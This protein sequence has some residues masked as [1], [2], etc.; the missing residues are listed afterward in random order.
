MEYNPKIFK[1][2]YYGDIK[3]DY[4]VNCEGVVMNS[5]T[6]KTL[7]WQMLQ[8]QLYYK[9]A[10][11]VKPLKGAKWIPVHRLVATAFIPNPLN[12]PC[13]NHIDGN[14][15]NNHVSNLEWVTYRENTLHALH[16]GLKPD[17]K[18][19]EDQVREI[20]RLLSTQRYTNRQIAEMIG[21][22]CTKG[23]VN[24]IR[25]RNSWTCISKD[26]DLPPIRK[27]KVKWKKRFPKI[28]ELLRAGYNNKQIIKIHPIPEV[29]KDAY[30]AIIST[31]KAFLRQLGE[32]Q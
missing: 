6:S 31:R 3:T 26:Y 2:I 23:M 11:Y 32:I 16:H 20:C 4:V 8:N 27:M 24:D 1:R 5:K 18:L 30:T 25:G 17:V 9:V 12:K 7:K 21:P 29:T 14:K 28:D 15:L 19:S 10:I 22:P 13:C